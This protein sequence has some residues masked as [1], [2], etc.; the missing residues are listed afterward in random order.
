MKR[1]TS[2]TALNAFSPFL[3]LALTMK[4][5]LRSIIVRFDLWDVMEGGAVVTSARLSRSECSQ[6]KNRCFQGHTQKELPFDP[7]IRSSHEIPFAKWQNSSDKATHSLQFMEEFCFGIYFQA[8]GGFAHKI[9]IFRGLLIHIFVWTGSQELAWSSQL[10][11]HD[12]N[13]HNWFFSLL[14][15]LR[16]FD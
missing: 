9:E 13:L 14:C 16:W 6:T 7:C 4:T 11:F 2:V 8:S 12:H 15:W 3:A 1:S 10:C 5:E